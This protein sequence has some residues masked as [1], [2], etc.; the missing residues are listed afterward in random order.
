MTI[1]EAF[2]TVDNI[3][4]IGLNMFLFLKF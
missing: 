3:K 2:K 1:K 4:K